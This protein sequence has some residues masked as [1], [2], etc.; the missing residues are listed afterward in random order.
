MH[1][2]VVTLPTLATL[3]YLQALFGG[4]VLPIKW[5]LLHV[6]LGTTADPDFKLDNSARYQATPGDID[7]WYDTASGRSWLI[8]PLFASPEMAARS[9]IIGDVF[10]VTFQAFMPLTDGGNNRRRNKSILN[11]IASSM[12]ASA[13]TLEFHGELLLPSQ[14]PGPSFADFRAAYTSNSLLSDSALPYADGF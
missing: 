1:Y 10:G 3:T 5:E 9:S 8:M 4:S 7:R 2:R 13:P 14:F 6:E 11:S 12:L